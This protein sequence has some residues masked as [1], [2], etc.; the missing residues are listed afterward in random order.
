MA[1]AWC[2]KRY[3]RF[4]IFE[5]G[6]GRTGSRMRVGNFREMCKIRTV[7]VKMEVILRVGGRVSDNFWLPT[8]ATNRGLACLQS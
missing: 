5:K 2:A 6:E 4:K 1:K 3:G 8:S 7:F